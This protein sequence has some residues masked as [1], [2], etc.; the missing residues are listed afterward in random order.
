MDQER[1]NPY[2]EVNKWTQEPERNY[3][4]YDYSRREIPTNF[5]K[6]TMTE[7]IYWENL[8]QMI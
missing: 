4:T 8:T 5:P 1:L 2:L 3:D 6:E 7:T